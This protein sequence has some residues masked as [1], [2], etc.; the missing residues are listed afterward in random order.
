MPSKPKRYAR[1]VVAMV[2]CGVVLFLLF[3]GA[4]A[5]VHAVPFN[6]IESNLRASAGQITSLYE[7]EYGEPRDHGLIFMPDRG[8]EVVMMQCVASTRPNPLMTSCPAD[9]AAVAVSLRGAMGAPEALAQALADDNFSAPVYPYFRYWHGYLV[10]LRL[11]LTV[12]DYHTFTIVN[13]L[14]L[15]LAAVWAVWG[16]ATRLSR[17]TAL[18]FGVVILIAAP[19]EIGGCLQFLPCFMIMLVGCAAALMWPRLTDTPLRMA[20]FF[21]TTGTL[22]VFFDFLTT[23]VITLGFPAALLIL[24]RRK[25]GCDASPLRSLLLMSVA[26]GAGYFGLWAAK[27]GLAAAY[28]ADIFADITQA[29]SL[30]A[31]SSTGF[32]KFD[33][34]MVPLTVGC[35]ILLV[36]AVVLVYKGYPSVPTDKALVVIALLPVVWTLITRNH[37]VVH[38]YFTWRSFLLSL[39]C[40]GVLSLTASSKHRELP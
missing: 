17:K 16:V 37:T 18:L 30:R 14:L 33:A 34:L 26:W 4:M 5:G 31:G 9:S 25:G 29:I 3:W 22:T 2:V 12:V 6:A 27:W 35:V 13:I 24:R 21:F 28:G 40:L 20:L 36:G 10:P 11:W 1:V 19:W 32:P 39:F 7:S 23:P 15:C 8:T 38:Y